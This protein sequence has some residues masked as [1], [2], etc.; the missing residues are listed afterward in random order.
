MTA[1]T[2][3]ENLRKYN[4]RFSIIVEQIPAFAPS[5]K[6]V[7]EVKLKCKSFKEI[8]RQYFE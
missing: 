5:T 6:L 8:A 7:R 1:I 3:T 4:S 2:N